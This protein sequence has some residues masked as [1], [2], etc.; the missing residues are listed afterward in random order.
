MH[1][2]ENG[3]AGGLIRAGAD[4]VDASNPQ[5]IFLEGDIE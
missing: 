3:F 4:G 2:G 1:P 5:S